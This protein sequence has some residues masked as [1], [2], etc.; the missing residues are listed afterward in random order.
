MHGLANGNAASRY[1]RLAD[2]GRAPLR[3]DD[4]R[5]AGGLF[6]LLHAERAVGRVV[7]NLADSYLRHVARSFWQAFLSGAV[8]SVVPAV[9]PPARFIDAVFL[10]AWRRRVWCAMTLLILPV[11]VAVSRYS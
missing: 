5:L 6:M 11:L 10:D 1:S 3:A 4:N 9:F 2:S 8:L 7:D